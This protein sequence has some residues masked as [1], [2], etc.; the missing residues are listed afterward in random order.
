MLKSVGVFSFLALAEIEV[1]WECIGRCILAPRP[2]LFFYIF[3]DAVDVIAVTAL[4]DMK[5]FSR[6]L[7]EAP[8][9]SHF[10]IT[11]GARRIALWKGHE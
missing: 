7:S 8:A 3:L 6:A 1:R 11:G 2:E 4:D 9:V 5:D 10:G